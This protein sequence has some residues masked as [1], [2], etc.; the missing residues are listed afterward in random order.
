[1]SQ[2]GHWVEKLIPEY[3]DTQGS[4]FESVKIYYVPQ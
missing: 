1:M 4:I 3:L 2:G